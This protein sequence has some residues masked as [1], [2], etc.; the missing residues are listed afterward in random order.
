MAYHLRLPHA[1]QYNSGQDEQDIQTQQMQ[2]MPAAL[3][4]AAQR[5]KKPFTYLP[6]GL[7]FSEIRSPSMAKR[8]A[9]H[10][11]N[12]VKVGTNSSLDPLWRDNGESKGSSFL[13]RLP[14]TAR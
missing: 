12:I 3:V 11:A 9:K 13:G 10:Q 8:L 7:D 4:G 6:G 2:A 1:G 14:P 5:E